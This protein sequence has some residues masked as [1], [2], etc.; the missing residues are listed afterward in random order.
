MK[1]EPRG[2]ERERR[3]PLQQ[4]SSVLSAQLGS[5]SYQ[6]SGRSLSVIQQEERRV[7]ARLHAPLLA[8]SPSLRSLSQLSE[9]LWAESPIADASAYMDKGSIALSAAPVDLALHRATKLLRDAERKKDASQRGEKMREE[10]GT[11]PNKLLMLLTPPPIEYRSSPTPGQPLACVAPSLGPTRES[12]SRGTPAA[13]RRL[14]GTTGHTKLSFVKLSRRSSSASTTV[15]AADALAHELVDV[16]APPAESAVA[17]VIA[18]EVECERG[19]AAD[20]TAVSASDE[21]AR[22]QPGQPIAS[23]L[24]SAYHEG[25]FE[26][27]LNML[28]GAL[29]LDPHNP[30]LHRIKSRTLSKL[31]DHR[32]A[33]VEAS[34][35][36]A[37]APQSS[38]SHLH[39]ADAL[40]QLGHMSA[41]GE[42][43]I[44]ALK[45]EPLGQAHSHGRRK[46]NAV[47][48]DVRRR[49]EF[50]PA[51]R[52]LVPSRAAAVDSE[53]GDG[54]AERSRPP[55]SPPIRAKGH[56]VRRFVDARRAGRAEAADE[57]A[58]GPRAPPPD[59]AQSE[60]DTDVLGASTN[61][62]TPIFAPRRTWRRRRTSLFEVVC[63]RERQARARRQRGQRRA[64]GAGGGVRRV[65][66]RERRQRAP[67]PPPLLPRPRACRA[68]NSAAQRHA[69]GGEARR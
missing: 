66:A 22:E 31:S 49:R 59:D 24:T 68:S 23:V 17:Q 57:S 3:L 63:G 43:L 67:P 19:E 27:T 61:L 39:R 40:A 11:L 4:P 64:A 38:L 50:A 33:V 30:A 46:Y 65:R 56:D 21:P 5:T 69:S 13:R 41:A 26:R 14:V 51:L 36:I 20:A 58:S 9:G 25:A 34:R 1:R 52:P 32:G 29:D 55:A 2:L 16:S 6:S 18:E 35:A 62:R 45:R 10:Y 12:M 60:G 47:L 8:H 54:S 28:V 53:L 48:S 44:E 15:T 7:A 42:S 37:L